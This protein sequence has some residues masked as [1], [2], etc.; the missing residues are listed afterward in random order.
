MGASRWVSIG[1]AL[2]GVILAV[3]LSKALGGILGWFKIPDYALLGASVTAT[4]VVAW[5][6]T[7]AVAVICWRNPRYNTLANEVVQELRKVTWP[8]WVETRAATI[9]VIITTVI[10]SI[11]L[12]FFD[13]IWSGLTGLIYT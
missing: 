2:G 10:I 7:A 6:A 8:T 3:V 5:I 13:M 1:F 11:I 9:V 4:T 12:Y